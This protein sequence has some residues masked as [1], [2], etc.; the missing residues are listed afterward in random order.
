MRF[1]YHPI[2]TFS[3]ANTNAST[4]LPVL[5]GK[6]GASSYCVRKGLSRKAQLAH[7]TRLYVCKNPDSL[8]KDAIPKTVILGYLAGVGG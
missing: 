8:L 7:F 3:G 6:H 1:L 4:G 5:A 2:V